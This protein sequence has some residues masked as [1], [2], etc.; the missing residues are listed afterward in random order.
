MTMFAGLDVSRQRLLFRACSLGAAPH[1][2]R[3]P[4]R[5]ERS[6]QAAID[7]ST[8]TPSSQPLARAQKRSNLIGQLD[9]AR[10][11]VSRPIASPPNVMVGH[12]SF[13]GGDGCARWR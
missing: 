1:P 11:I 3:L 4:A 5:F 10:R 8:M 13:V 12:R 6:H 2:R 7:N 9:G